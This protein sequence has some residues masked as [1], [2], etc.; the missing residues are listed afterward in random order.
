MRF[1]EMTQ[2]VLISRPT[3]VST[4]NV[5]GLR[6]GRGNLYRE[7]LKKAKEQGGNYLNFNGYNK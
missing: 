4:P 5:L 7:A 6:P 3:P 1:A 2:D